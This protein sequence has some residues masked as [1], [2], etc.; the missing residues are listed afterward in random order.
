M[1]VYK[2]GEHSGKDGAPKYDVAYTHTGSKSKQQVKVVK[3][4]KAKALAEKTK[5]GDYKVYGKKSKQAKSYR[6][7]FSAAM[8]K[9]EG[10]QFTW[11]G[12]KHVAKYAKKKK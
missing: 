1:H 5:G 3:D 12:Q 11:D 6:E 4:G 7:A 8:K 2:E 9:G 10:T